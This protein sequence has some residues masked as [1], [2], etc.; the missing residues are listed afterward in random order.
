VIDVSWIIS[1][2]RIPQKKRGGP[3]KYNRSVPGTFI[4]IPNRFIAYCD[5]DG[6]R[7]KVHV[8]DTGRYHK[9]P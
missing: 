7:T 5:I 9:L 3:M 1:G 2:T 8:K 4:R 6:E